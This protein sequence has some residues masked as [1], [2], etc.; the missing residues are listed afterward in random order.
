MTFRDELEQ[1]TECQHHER[2][3]C[4]DLMCQLRGCHDLDVYW[5]LAGLDEE[6]DGAR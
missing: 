2:G 4:D 3:P 1:L 5:V 6:A